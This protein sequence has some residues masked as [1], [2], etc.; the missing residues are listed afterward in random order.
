MFHALLPSPQQIRNDDNTTV[1]SGGI[2]IYQTVHPLLVRLCVEPA[3]IFDVAL[4]RIRRNKADQ[5]ENSILLQRKVLTGTLFNNL[6]CDFRTSFHAEES[7]LH[8]RT[9]ITA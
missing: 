1:D 3:I 2:W 6:P 4:K 5:G 8:I 9:Y 7:Y